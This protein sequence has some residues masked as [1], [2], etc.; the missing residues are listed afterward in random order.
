MSRCRL[1]LGLF[2]LLLVLISAEATRGAGPPGE[3]AVVCGDYPRAFFFRSSES[4]AANPRVSFDRW[5]AAFSRLMGIEGKVLD[6]EVP[7][8]SK[9][10]IAFFTRFKRLHPGQLV[11]LHYNGN[12]RDPRYQTENS[13]PAT[14]SITWGPGFCPTF[15][16]NRARRRSG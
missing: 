1:R 15:R 8:R 13:S 11:L 4:V 5:D 10:N 2:L 7:G 9:R 3:P 12:A 14:S 6:E 16:P